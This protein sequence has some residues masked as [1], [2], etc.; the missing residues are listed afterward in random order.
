[1]VA[2]R[3]DWRAGSATLTT[4]PSMK[5]MLEAMIVAARVQRLRDFMRDDLIEPSRGSHDQID[6][7]R[8][9]VPV[10]QLGVQPF[11]ACGGQR[12][13]RPLLDLRLFPRDV[14]NALRDG[15][16]VL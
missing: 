3:L 15:P 14:L 2:C 5:V 6:R 13:E 10:G 12:V 1:M 16:A 8:Q 11:S 4:V 9:T 7:V